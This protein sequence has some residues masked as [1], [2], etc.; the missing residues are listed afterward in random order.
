MDGYDCMTDR[1]IQTGI[2]S[3]AN[4][5]IDYVKSAPNAIMLITKHLQQVYVARPVLKEVGQLKTD[6]IKNLDIEIVEPTLPQIIEATQIRQ[7]QSSLSG[8]DAI[9]FVM[10]RDNRWTCLTNDKPLRNICAKHNVACLWGLEIMLGL[11]ST[12]ALPAGK[13]YKIAQD[14]QSK[15]HYIKIK[16]LHEFKKKLGV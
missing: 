13:A 4:V 8:Q 10:A 15:N 1:I 9:C 6:N 3:D 11:V 12:G 14:I 2:I 5:L 7:S 16:T